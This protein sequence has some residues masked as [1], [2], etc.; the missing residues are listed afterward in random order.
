MIATHKSRTSW[1]FSHVR[2]SLCLL[3]AVVLLNSCGAP[4]E[5]P[6]TPT[7]PVELASATRIETLVENSRGRVLVLNFWATWCPPC[8]EEMPELAS[9]ARNHVGE[10]VEFL[11]V[12]SDEPS[13][14]YTEV[15]PFA[16][17]YDLPFP[18]YIMG[19]N[20]PAKMV[21][22]IGIEWEGGLP[23]TFIFNK[24]GRAVHSWVGPVDEQILMAAVGPLLK[25]ESD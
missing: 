15:S 4:E 18:V 25:P 23:A 14:R 7:H 3:A 2:S 12:S 8:V 11:S 5:V 1:A 24:D 17:E 22:H 19:V 10:E 9:F 20:H 21:E 6:A 16:I 13:T